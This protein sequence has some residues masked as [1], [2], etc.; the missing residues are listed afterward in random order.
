MK[1]NLVNFNG[2]GKHYTEIAEEYL[3]YINH[4]DFNLSIDEACSYLS[5]TYTYFLLN[6]RDSLK[7]IYINIPARKM[8]TKLCNNNPDEKLNLD[9]LRKKVLYSKPDFFKFIFDN[10][11]VEI[12][13]KSYT[14]KD[15]INKKAINKLKKLYVSKDILQVLNEHS[16]KLYGQPKRSILINFNATGDDLPEQFCGISE[17]MN[18]TNC[19]H[20]NQI[21]RKAELFG[22]KKY[23]F[24][25]LM[26]YDKN[27]FISNKI[28]VN[29]EK[30][31]EI[32]NDEVIINGIINSALN[33]LN[34]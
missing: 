19:K 12:K 20:Y 21:Y 26:R 16:K 33:K 32:G 6:F 29:Y 25:N 11:K 18:F 5:C 10:L 15:A 3:N 1:S 2:V 13:Y 4:K 9:L 8:I 23:R 27:D 24:F 30:Y 31:L 17:L 22:V 34:D 7:H 28:L 14:Y